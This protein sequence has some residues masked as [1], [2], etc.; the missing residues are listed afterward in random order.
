METVTPPSRIL[1][2]EP[3]PGRSLRLAASATADS[4]RSASWTTRARRRRNV[5]A[6]LRIGNRKCAMSVRSGDRLGT[7]PWRSHREYACSGCAAMRADNPHRVHGCVG[8]F[9]ATGRFVHKVRRNHA[10]AAV[11]SRSRI[12]VIRAPNA[13][14]VGPWDTNG[15]GVPEG[16]AVGESPSTTTPTFSLNEPKA[17][18]GDANRCVPA[19]SGVVDACGTNRQ[20]DASIHAGA[21]QK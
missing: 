17:E 6:T 13:A 4:I 14:G 10:N 9:R 21:A 7:R 11:A 12:H 8:N 16:D 3:E 1:F 2:P 5:G 19:T 15:L 18:T 20:F